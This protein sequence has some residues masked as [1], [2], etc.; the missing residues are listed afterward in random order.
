MLEQAV[1]DLLSRI[2]D[3]WQEYRPDDLTETQSQGLFLLVAAGMVERRERLR[4][5]MFN[6]P[7]V[8]EATITC[9]GEYGGVEALQPLIASLWSD[10][11]DAFREWKK[12]D[13]AN[14]P[15]AHCGRLEPSEWRLTVR[16]DDDGNTYNRVQRFDVLGIDEPEKDAFDTDAGAEQ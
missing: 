13:A 3:T 8:A 2:P 10:W 4:M 14:M 16:R 12:G 1:S 15:P 9:T 6:Q 5:R 7:L 11:Q